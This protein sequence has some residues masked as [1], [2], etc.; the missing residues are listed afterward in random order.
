MKEKVYVAAHLPFDKKGYAESVY[1]ELKNTDEIDLEEIQ[2]HNNYIWCR[3]YMPVK[4]STGKLVQFTFAPPYMTESK[5]WK[6]R[7]PN[8][9]KIHADLS[10]DYV[11]SNIILDGGA[12][13]VCGRKAIVSDRVF[14]DNK[15]LK[16]KVIIDEI[17]KSLDLDQLIIIPQY[18]GDFTGH[19]DGLVRFVDQ[20]RVVTNDL[21]EELK[22]LKGDKNHYRKNLIEN[23]VYAFK[24]ALISAGLELEYLPF[25]VRKEENE[26]L[27]DDGIYTNFL[28]LEK[29]II[30]PVYD[31]KSDA[32]AAGKLEKFY[33][34]P[35][36]KIYASHLANEGGMINCITWTR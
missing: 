3:D 15:N 1:K 11:K 29:L 28:L 12:I 31:N 20:K 17:I 21:D 27:K 4:S 34:R 36:K 14:R 22:V 2:N 5:K 23:W 25:A 8:T 30:M 13:E 19:V 10:L 35:V 7:I 24:S 9:N 26:I 6:E 18:P 33:K 16:E 32:I